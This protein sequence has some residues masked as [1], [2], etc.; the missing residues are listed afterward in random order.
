MP[1]N[2]GIKVPGDPDVDFAAIMARMRQLSRADI[3]KK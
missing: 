3:S 2:L 1:A